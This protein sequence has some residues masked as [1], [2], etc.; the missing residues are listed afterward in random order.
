[1]G[2]IVE[3]PQHRGDRREK[4]ADILTGSTKELTVHLCCTKAE[5]VDQWEI[6]ICFPLESGVRGVSGL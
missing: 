3:T 1:V 2:H 4:A 5:A 6:D